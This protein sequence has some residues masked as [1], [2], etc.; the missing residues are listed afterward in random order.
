MMES[1][2][3]SKEIT[4]LVRLRSFPVLFGDWPDTG[5]PTRM[6]PIDLMGQGEMGTGGQDQTTSTLVSTDVWSRPVAQRSLPS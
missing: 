3:G 4:A 6:F 2:S 5:N 1:S